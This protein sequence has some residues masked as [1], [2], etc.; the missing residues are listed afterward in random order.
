MAVQYDAFTAGTDLGGM[1]TKNDIRILV[2]YILKTLGVPFSRADLCE[3]LGTTA[4]VNFFEVND[5]LDAVAQAGLVSCQTKDGGELFTLTDAGREVA[6][7]L[8]TDLPLHVRS[9]AVSSAIEL[10]AREK[11]R[12]GTQARVEKVGDGYRAILS[13]SDGDTLMMQTVLYAADSLQADSLCEAF[14]RRPGA[15]YSGIV[16]TL[17]HNES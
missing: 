3:A 9:T 7:R 17:T 14:L 8:E 10:L 12:G 1:R 15:L 11:A 4:L 16:E 13:V 5:A 2:C 6:D